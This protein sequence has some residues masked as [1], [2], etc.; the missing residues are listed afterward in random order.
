MGDLGTA[1][2][3]YV[4]GP[5]CKAIKATEE[6]VKPRMPWWEVLAMAVVSTFIGACAVVGAL[7]VGLRAALHYWHF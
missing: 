6:P 2:R 1:D 7:D 3:T 5:D 4:C